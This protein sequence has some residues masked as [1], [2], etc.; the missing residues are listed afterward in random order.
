MK[1]KAPPPA[2]HMNPKAVFEKLDDHVYWQRIGTTP[3][4]RDRAVLEIGCAS[5]A[6][7][8]KIALAGAKEVVGIDIVPV[9]IEYAR[10]KVKEY[11]GIAGRVTFEIS[12]LSNL[13]S[14]H[15]DIAISKDTFEHVMNVDGALREI[16]R[17]LKP[18]GAFYLG[19]SPLYCSPFGF[20][21][22]MKRSIFKW[23]PCEIPWL[24]LLFPDAYLMKKWNETH[25]T[26]KRVVQDVGLNK[27]KYSAYK[28]LLAKHFTFSSWKTN[29]HTGKAGRCLSLLSR[30]PFLRDFCIINVYATLRKP[31]A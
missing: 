2:L 18:G 30:V 26:K 21:R 12:D 22:V 24:H 7:S 10:E 13:P 8:I 28:T 3:D 31:P 6:L 5:G 15:F 16:Q 4:V 1:T 11:P 19:F 20:H 9:L 17:V 23:L 29:V 25:G 27:V 14:N